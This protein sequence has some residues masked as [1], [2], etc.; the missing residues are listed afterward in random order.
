MEE[1]LDQLPNLVKL[2]VNGCIAL[3]RLVLRSCT[4]LQWLDCSGRSRLHHVTSSSPALAHMDAVACAN[5]AVSYGPD[6]CMPAG[7]H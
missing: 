4:K 5:L 1:A 3:T 6:V 7:V 2:N